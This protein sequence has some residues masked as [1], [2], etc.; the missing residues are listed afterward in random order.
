MLGKKPMKAAG[1]ESSRTQVCESPKTGEGSVPGGPGRG[2][3]RGG[4]RHTRNCR[5]S[6]K[7][8]PVLKGLIKRDSAQESAQA[9]NC[10]GRVLRL[11]LT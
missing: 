9:G 11:E 3:V 8:L 6:L 2:G 10:G 5:A 1:L 7:K 4:Q